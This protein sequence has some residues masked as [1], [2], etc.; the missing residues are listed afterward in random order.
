MSTD[1]W[2]ATLTLRTEAVTPVQLA[3]F[4]AASGDHNPLHLDSEAAR[5]A[6]FERPLVHGMFSMAI[7]ARMFTH[8]FGPGCVR[9]LQTRFTGVALVGELL[10]MSAT[11]Q[12][13]EGDRAHYAVRGATGAGSEVLA[14]T[15][16]VEA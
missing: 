15:A 6:G 16:Q 1:G 3:L 8:R 13:V 11:L 9:L 4:A 12:R 7:A 5:R 2:P 10:E 14:G